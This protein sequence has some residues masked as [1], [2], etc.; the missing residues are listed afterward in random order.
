[1][2]SISSLEAKPLA[3]KAVILLTDGK[4]DTGDASKDA[5]SIQ[6]I[7]GQ[8]LSDYLQAGVKIYCVAFS[9][10]SDWNLLDYLSRQTG[11]LAVRGNDPEQLR[12]L[13]LRLFEEIAQPQSVPLEDSS[14]LLDSSVNEV[15]FVVTHPKANQS[16]RVVSPD[17]KKQI[18]QKK[19]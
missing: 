5:A 15:T 13:F 17:G 11:A 10:Q 2:L 3:K 8:I 18:E 6:S 9:K 1:M 12:Q 16:L 4:V 14:A 19:R 7:R